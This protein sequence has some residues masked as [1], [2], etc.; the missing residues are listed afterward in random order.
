[1]GKITR[2]Q[3]QRRYTDRYNIHI[4][5]KYAGW[6]HE[7]VLINSKMRKGDEISND[8]FSKLLVENQ[9]RDA[10]EKGIK[11]ASTRVRSEWEIYSYLEKKDYDEAALD[12]AILRL[13]E[14]NYID[15]ENFAKLFL[16]DAINVSRKG[17]RVIR[18]DLKRRGIG[19]SILESTINEYTIARQLV[20][21]ELLYEKLLKRHIREEDKYKK[22]KKITDSLMRKGFAWDV[23]SKVIDK[24]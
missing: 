6:I 23:I 1:M 21:V 9:S 11:F 16:R 19:E 15:D 8:D 5:N 7:I 20:V 2:I 13:K 14:Y 18:M 22:R 17:P 4:D 3:P 24:G 12:Y 10:F